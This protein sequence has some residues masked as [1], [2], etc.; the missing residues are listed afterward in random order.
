MIRKWLKNLI[1][2]ISSWNYI[3]IRNDSSSTEEDGQILDLKWISK[4]S[5]SVGLM[6]LP[7]FRNDIL[8]KI[9]QPLKALGQMSPHFLS[10]GGQTGQN[11]IWDCITKNQ[12]FTIT[13]R[14]TWIST[15]IMIEIAKN[16]LI[17][18]S[19]TE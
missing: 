13:T 12:N 2:E 1:F 15:R 19:L 8:N 4:I 17:I 7:K 16:H 11:F 5:I 10:C 9:T 6:F 14:L 18:I 3:L